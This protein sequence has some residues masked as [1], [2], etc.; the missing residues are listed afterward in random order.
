MSFATVRKYACPSGVPMRSLLVPSM[1]AGRS[2][3]SCNTIKLASGC[4][5]SAS[6]LYSTPTVIRGCGC[7]ISVFLHFARSK[8]SGIIRTPKVKFHN[9]PACSLEPLTAI[10]SPGQTGQLGTA[11]TGAGADTGAAAA[12]SAIAPPNPCPTKTPATRIL[13]RRII[14]DIIILLDPAQLT[15]SPARRCGDHRANPPLLK[16]HEAD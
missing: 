11:D 16:I 2:D 14:G 10:P 15:L 9:D 13:E 1:T 6:G 4:T 7:H 8:M 5:S 12:S 3:V